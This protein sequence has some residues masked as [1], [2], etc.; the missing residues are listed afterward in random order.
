MG[1]KKE[2]LKLNQQALE[3]QKRVLGDEHPFTLYSMRV[4]LQIFRDL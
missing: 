1:R 3:M 2:A 4:R